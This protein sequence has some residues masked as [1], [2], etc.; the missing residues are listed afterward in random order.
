LITGGAWYPSSGGS[1][2]ASYSGVY[3]TALWGGNG[4]P[5]GQISYVQSASNTAVTS[6]H[7]DVGKVDANGTAV[8]PVVTR[9]GP[10]GSLYYL[11]TTYETSGGSIQ[12]VKYT[13]APTVAT[14]SIDPPGGTY[15]N[16]FSASITVATAGASIHYTTDFSEPTISSPIYLTPIPI[17]SSTIIKAKAFL[18]GSNPSSTASSAYVIG[19]PAGNLPPL[20]DAG[21]NKTVFVDQVTVLDGSGTTD[22]DGDDEFLTGEMWTQTSGPAVTILDGTEEIAS[23]TPI[24]QGLYVFELEVSDG[25]DTGTDQVEITVVP[26]WR[27]RDGLVSLYQFKAKQGD[28][29]YDTGALGPPVDLTMSDLGSVI[30]GTGYISLSTPSIIKGSGTKL[31]QLCMS[32]DAISIEAWI[33]PASLDQSGPARILSLSADP[34]NRNFTL[35]QDNTVYDFRLRTSSTNDNGQPSIQTQGNSVTTMLTQ[36]VFT[37]SSN[38]TA[39]IYKDGLEE[40][41]VSLSGNLSNWNQSYDLAIGNELSEDRP[42]LGEVN[43]IAIY[44]RALSAQEVM[45]NF[46]AFNN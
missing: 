39:T 14:P 15:S 17:S 5:K 40:N 29:S 11:L 37:W 10:D 13:S 44:C 38:G 2:P 23:F 3:F 28:R 24:Q 27:V 41:S 7:D 45:Q 30:W 25:V 19:D 9:I 42:W 22:P 36:V 1:F 4:D 8:K 43:E 35:A 34:F 46:N 31:T 33:K 21:E 12:R 16:G 6:F 32:S 18:A 26:A 20:V